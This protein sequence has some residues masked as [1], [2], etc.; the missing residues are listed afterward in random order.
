MGASNFMLDAYESQLNTMNNYQEL[1]QRTSAAP[2]PEL[3]ARLLNPEVTT[4]LLEVCQCIILRSVDLDKIK[5]HIF[6][7]KP[8]ST[9]GSALSIPEITQHLLVNEKRMKII[10]GIIGIATEAGE[11]LEKLVGLLVDGED[12]DTINLKEEAGDNFWYL[13]ELLTGA[14]STFSE[15]QRLNIAKLAARYGDKF[16][17]FKALNRDLDKERGVLEQVSCAACD[18]GDFTIGHSDECPKHEKDS[19]QA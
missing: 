12:F 11:L 3:F 6:Y 9:D 1:A 13:A 4:A 5:K 15:V 2:T 7:G 19:T 17:E 18:R 14:D 16:T 8:L 10:H